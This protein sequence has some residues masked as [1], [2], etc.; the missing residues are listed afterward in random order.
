MSE[1][2]VRLFRT[3]TCGVYVIGVGREERRSAFTAAWLVQASFDPLLL[4]LSVN[5]GHASF[6]LLVEGGGFSVNVLGRGQLQLARHFGTQSG[7]DV[8][9][10]AGIAWRPGRS[11]APLL[12]DALAHFECELAARTRAGDH[13]IVLGRVLGGALL[14]PQAA[15]M[16]YADMD[17]LDGSSA[18]YP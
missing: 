13:E 4:A 15:P 16:S 5:P 11:G 2:P 18:L 17:D 6:P 8:D 1:S 3:L 14:A 12:L 10:L 9:K 7:R